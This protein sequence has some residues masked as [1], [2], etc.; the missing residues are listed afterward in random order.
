MN[1]YV[2]FLQMID[3]TTY[4]IIMSGEYEAQVLNVIGNYMSLKDGKLITDINC[5]KVVIN[6]G[7][8]KYAY[9]KRNR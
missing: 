1:N 8:V 3:N 5:K 9:I 2:V 4:E 6:F 7:L